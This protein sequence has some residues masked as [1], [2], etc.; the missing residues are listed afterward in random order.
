[1]A[2]FTALRFFSN[3]QKPLETSADNTVKMLTEDGQL[4]AIDKSLL[5]SSGQK[6]AHDDIHDWIKK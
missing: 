1:V 3:K 2:S 6:I 5:A 4:V